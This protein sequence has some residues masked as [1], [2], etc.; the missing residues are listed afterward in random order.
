MGD[1]IWIEA[2]GRAGRETHNDMSVL[3][4]LDKYLDVLAEKLGVA[5]LTEFYDYGA[6]ADDFDDDD[7]D[8]GKDDDEIDESDGDEEDDDSEEEERD[9][10]QLTGRVWFDSAKGLE[11]VKTLREHLEK[12]FDALN[13]KPDE[14][15][16]HFPRSLL[17]DLQFC[18]TILDEAV[19]NGRKFHLLIV[20]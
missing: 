12:D 4:R 18:Q 19:A 17:E 20:A 5:K 6:M 13:W 9:D 8:G 2:Q 10:V 7:A 16:R 3:L 11:T 1:T 14:S 15:R